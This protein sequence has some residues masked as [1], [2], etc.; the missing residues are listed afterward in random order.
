MKKDVIHSAEIGALIGLAASIVHRPSHRPRGESG[1]SSV[2]VSRYRRA[3][4]LRLAGT[5][6]RRDGSSARSRTRVVSRNGRSSY[7]HAIRKLLD[8]DLAARAVR[9]PMTARSPL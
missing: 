1:L 3:P 7:T 5:G 2:R 8:E 6:R 4:Q 9:T